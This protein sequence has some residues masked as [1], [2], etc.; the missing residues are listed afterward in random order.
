MF[1]QGNLEAATY[2]V[3]RQLLTG[4]AQTAA[5]PWTATDF[6]NAL[7][8]SSTSGILSVFDCQNTN[9]MF[10]DIRNASDFTTN[11]AAGQ[12]LFTASSDVYSPGAS[13]AV[14]VLRVGYIYPLYF[15]GW[16][17]RWGLNSWGGSSGS[18]T[19]NMVATVVFKAE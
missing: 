1:N 14:I 9:K 4:A 12:S 5:T 6:R 19:R 11:P 17:G 7:C 8:N 2:T 13:G 10:I 3:S 18:S 16:I 15:T